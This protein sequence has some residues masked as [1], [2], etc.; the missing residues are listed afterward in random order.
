MTMG[1]DPRFPH[2]LSHRDWTVLLS[3][4][5]GEIGCDEGCGLFH[6]DCRILSRHRLTLDGAAPEWVSSDAVEADLWGASLRV[7]RAGGTADG[8]ELPQDAIEVRIDRRLGRGMVERIDVLN[9]SMTPRAVELAI[10]LGA[11]FADVLE[12]AMDQRQQTGNLSTA[13]GAEGIEIRYHATREEW[14]T[15]RGLRIRCTNGDL[16][17]AT[18]EIGSATARASISLDPRGS[19]SATLRFEPLVDGAWQEAAADA[20]QQLT[21]RAD[22]ARDNLFEPSTGPGSVTG[23]FGRGAKSTSLYT[24]V[25][26][27]HPGR[28]RAAKAALLV[29]AVAAVRRIG[30]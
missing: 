23:D 9:H 17:L 7:A 16:A 1:L 24:T 5:D 20:K 14:S 3:H 18:G 19:W 30:R 11:D 8:P 28:K 27:L 13:G 29:A 25:F 6:H 2:E 21:R 10:E 15:E 12:V 4:P 26:E 22:D